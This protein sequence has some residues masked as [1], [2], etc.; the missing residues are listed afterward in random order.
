MVSIG[1]E[2]EEQIDLSTVFDMLYREVFPANAGLGG[3]LAALSES[4]RHRGDTGRSVIIAVL[5][6][7]R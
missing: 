1:T 3:P 2:N 6:E 7:K 4:Q 5:V